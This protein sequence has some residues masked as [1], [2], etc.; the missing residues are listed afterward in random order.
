MSAARWFFAL[1]CV[2]SLAACATGG[3]ARVRDIDGKPLPPY[4][5]AD[6][7][8]PIYTVT[9]KDGQQYLVVTNRPA[10]ILTSRVGEVLRFRE[11]SIDDVCDRILASGP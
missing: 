8:G 11:K 6:A 2:A 10:F 4:A 3:P 9:C 7:T 5:T 1:A